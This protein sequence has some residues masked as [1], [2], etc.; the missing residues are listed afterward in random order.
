MFVN[1]Y[2]YF[3]ELFPSSPPSPPEDVVA[4]PESDAPCAD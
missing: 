4:Q 3:E 2:L 1:P